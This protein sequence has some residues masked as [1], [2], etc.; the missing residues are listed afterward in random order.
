M[1]GLFEKLGERRPQQTPAPKP[2]PLA[3]PVLLDW[4]QR[5]WTKPTISLRDIYRHGPACVRWNKGSALKAAENLERSGWLIAIKG[6]GLTRK[7][8][9]ITAGPLDAEFGRVRAR[10]KVSQLNGTH[11]R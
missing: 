10:Y 9:Q 11:L 1:A 5:F 4:L 8:W 6:P 3:A 2:V 7:R